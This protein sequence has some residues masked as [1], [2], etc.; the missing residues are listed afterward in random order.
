MADRSHRPSLL[1]KSQLAALIP[2][3][4]T[5]LWHVLEGCGRLDG[6][7]VLSPADVKS[8][9]DAAAARFGLERQRAYWT[10]LPYLAAL[11]IGGRDRVL[12]DAQCEPLLAALARPR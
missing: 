2:E 3:G 9:V 7:V 10:V 1:L 5:D 6:G 11:V 4:V 12:P 8:L